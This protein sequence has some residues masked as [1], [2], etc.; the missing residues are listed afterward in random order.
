MPVTHN[1]QTIP[2]VTGMNGSMFGARS[3][4]L[5]RAVDFR[6]VLGELVRN[7]L[8]ATPEQLGRILPGYRDPAELLERGGVSGVDGVRI[9]GEPGIV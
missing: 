7:H 2:W 6:S 4:Y 9:F 5:K 1:G 8:G 3:R